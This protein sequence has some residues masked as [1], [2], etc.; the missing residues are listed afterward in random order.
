MRHV[1][2]DRPKRFGKPF[3]SGVLFLNDLGVFDHRNSAAF[4]DFALYGNALAAVFC[5]L[6]V[7]RLVLANDEVR[8]AVAHDAG[9]AARFDA[10]RPA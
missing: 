2:T 9:W 3:Q 5:K 1:A 10:L 4:R 6:I 7:Y 8:F